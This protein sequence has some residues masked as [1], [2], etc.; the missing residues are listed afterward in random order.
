METYANWSLKLHNY[1][2]EAGGGDCATNHRSAAAVMALAAGES[3][4][5]SW[6]GEIIKAL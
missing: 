3:V 5:C 1:S 6:P 2:G 4:W